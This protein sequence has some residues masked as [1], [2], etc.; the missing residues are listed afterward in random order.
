[1]KMNKHDYDLLDA[2][3]ALD[4]SL[5]HLFRRAVRRGT[6][7]L[8]TMLAD[9]AVSRDGQQATYH[10]MARDQFVHGHNHLEAERVVTGN[11]RPSDF[12]FFGNPLI[13]D[14]E[15]SGKDWAS[16]SSRATLGRHLIYTFEF[17]WDDPAF[18][19]EQ[20]RWA[21]PLKA[22]GKSPFGK[23]FSNLKGLGDFRLMN[24][25][26]SG[27]KSLHIHLVFETALMMDRLKAEVSPAA[28]RA[29]YRAHWLRL[30]D[31]VIEHLRPSGGITPDDSLATSTALRSMPNGHRIVGDNHPL[32]LMPGSR[33]RQ[34]VLW[35]QCV[36]R[37]AAKEVFLSPSLFAAKPMHRQRGGEVAR[38]ALL[39]DAQLTYAEGWF[40]D[41]YSGTGLVLAGI[42]PTND[43]YVARFHNSKADAN[44]AS[45]LTEAFVTPIL[46]GRDSERVSTLRPL[47]LPFGQLLDHLAS[48]VNE[49]KGF[50]PAELAIA[51]RR[52]GS[53]VPYW[54]TGNDISLVHAGEG[55][56]KSTSIMRHIDFS[57]TTGRPGQPSMFA[58]AT[59]DDAAMKA[60]E[61]NFSRA[62]AAGGQCDD[63]FIGVVWRSFSRLY[64]DMAG[65][66][67][68]LTVDDADEADASL[69]ALIQM[70]QPD[71]AKAMAEELAA[72]WRKIDGRTPVLFTV[73]DAAHQWA[74]NTLTRRMLCFDFFHDSFDPAASRARTEL[75]WLVHDEVSISTFLDRFTDEEMR[76]LQGLRASGAR[77]WSSGG[78]KR[79]REVYQKFTDKDGGNCAVERADAQRALRAGL[80]AFEP[81]VISDA[82]EYGF[83]NQAMTPFGCEGQRYFIRCRDWWMEGERP[84]ANRVMFLTT[85]IVPSL[86]ARKAVPSLTYLRPTTSVGRDVVGVDA[87]RRVNAEN[88][89]VI[90]QQ[91]V[92]TGTW[93]IANKLDGAE[94]TISPFAVRGR[95]DL[96]DADIVQIVTTFH[97]HYYRELQALGTWLGRDDLA[98]LAHVDQINQSSGR[99]RG[100][101]NN[102]A[103]HKVHI[104][105]TL[106]RAIMAN[107]VVRDELRYGWRLE[108]DEVQRKNARARNDGPTQDDGEDRR[109]A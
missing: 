90:A 33:V 32:G 83:Q 47:P 34:V 87:A 95:N 108:M 27:G 62:S 8:E 56:G 11:A 100:P 59:Y 58:F 103:S 1:M 38:R 104:N 14:P 77:V 85:E 16:P 5:V 89:P 24:V 15:G 78:S 99:N 54:I 75:N 106:F 25:T 46:R 40:Q 53:F 18:L 9:D 71:V 97:P 6:S 69:W 10:C 74:D 88:A 48:E 44:P 19:V 91:Y 55:V 60:Q 81:I 26:Y 12:Q 21:M 20:C 98:L 82:A 35:E 57:L 23:L 92:G 7:K 52:L 61:F 4:K 102:G 39:T 76:W 36:E 30:Q 17:D 51:R 41:F 49:G 96:A 86:I 107:A 42:E 68:L 64:S 70:L 3:E 109:A 72:I 67:E 22:W 105:L 66:A 79:Q 94:H 45:M 63:E 13:V 65:S 101:R 80:E 28:V 2:V 31:V 43:G 50:D 37:N 29:G 93:V 73:H 84:V